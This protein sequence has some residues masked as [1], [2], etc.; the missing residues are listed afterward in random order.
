[1]ELKREAGR[2]PAKSEH[3]SPFRNSIPELEVLTKQ[4]LKSKL[5]ISQDMEDKILDQN[6][7]IARKVYD[8]ELRSCCFYLD[9]RVM[10]YFTKIIVLFIF[11]V[12]FCVQLF[13]IDN[14]DSNQLYSSL[15]TLCLGIFLPSPRLTKDDL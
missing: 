1:M 9:K 14:C 4:V 11:C 6:L 13:R 8:N 3:K 2:S 15:L 10:E 7:S 12:F 5:P